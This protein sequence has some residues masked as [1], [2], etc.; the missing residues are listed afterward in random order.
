MILKTMHVP[1][2]NMIE[3]PHPYT[4]YLSCCFVVHCHLYWHSP[5]SKL[6]L[7]VIHWDNSSL[8]QSTSVS[9][10][11]IRLFHNL[12]T[13]YKCAYNLFWFQVVPLCSIS[14]RKSAK[15][16]QLCLP[17]EISN[18]RSFNYRAHTTEYR[19]LIER[20]PLNIE[21]W[22]YSQ[23]CIALHSCSN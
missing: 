5:V 18:E 22:F 16:S 7:I 23:L 2:M 8:R 17:T 11:M 10:R 21:S 12:Y 1:T 3:L 4:T 20:T 19:E 13:S 9:M 15:K 14:T 6:K